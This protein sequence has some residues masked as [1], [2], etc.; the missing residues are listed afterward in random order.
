[1]SGWRD[2]PTL[3]GAHVTL[4]PLVPADRDA[5]ALAAADQTD[6]FYANVT[7]FTDP[8]AA[9]AAL[10]LEREH[11]RA[12]PF[13]VEKPDGAVVGLTRYMRMNEGHRRL[14]IG[15]T[16]YARAVQRTGLNT[17]AKLLL[18]RHA[19]EVMGCNVV[20]IRTDW[21]NKRSQAA[22]ERLGAKRDGVLRHHQLMDGRLRDVVVYSIIAPE[23]PGVE[24]NLRHL[25]ARGGRA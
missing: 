14:E 11:G 13:A 10:F 1:M 2:P 23:W 3:A 24:R 8:D 12:M 17:E 21:F 25:L 4:R 20:Q 9:M 22:I 16:F 19:F 18:L 7:T 6:L 5:L 15:G